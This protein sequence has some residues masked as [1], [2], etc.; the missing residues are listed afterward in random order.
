MTPE[1]YAVLT[2][3]WVFLRTL[4]IAGPFPI[5]A[6]CTVGAWTLRGQ[7]DYAPKALARVVLFSVLAYLAAIA[8][9]ALAQQ[10]G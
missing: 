10:G 4:A 3:T 1:A 2:A 9:Q 5:V 8:L 7:R 6:A